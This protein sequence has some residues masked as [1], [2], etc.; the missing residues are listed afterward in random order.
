MSVSITAILKAS[1]EAIERIDGVSSPPLLRKLNGNQL[2]TG[3]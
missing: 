1:S 3:F 2:T